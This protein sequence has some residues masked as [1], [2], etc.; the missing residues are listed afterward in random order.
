MY[1]KERYTPQKRTAR[2]SRSP[3]NAYA[4]KFLQPKKRGPA[5]TKP[6]T[7]GNVSECTH[8]HGSNEAIARI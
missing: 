6:G 2:T 1:L 5:R 7:F 3:K 4:R 8:S